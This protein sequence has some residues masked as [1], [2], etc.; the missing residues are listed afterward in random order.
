MNK[1]H[2][3][4]L[5]ALNAALLLALGLTALAPERAPAQLGGSGGEFLMVAG[6]T[7]Q[8]NQQQVV[9]ILEKNTGMLAAGLFS[10]NNNNWEWIDA[11]PV[12]AEGG[13]GR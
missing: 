13:R 9:Y 2:L 11:R 1:R 3:K 6:D 4:G 12:R 5:L 8:R 7:R 10:S